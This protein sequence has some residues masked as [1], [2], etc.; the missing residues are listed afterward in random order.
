MEL[1]M[2]EPRSRPGL[3]HER[4]WVPRVV[5]AVSDLKGRT[6]FEEGAEIEGELLGL[7]SDDPGLERQA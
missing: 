6:G 4:E 5:R 1:E 2:G 7:A 3:D